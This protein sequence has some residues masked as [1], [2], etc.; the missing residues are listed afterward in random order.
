MTVLLQA[1]FP[2]LRK[3]L[4]SSI[5]LAT[6]LYACA[7][8]AQPAIPPQA[9][10]IDW[11]HFDQL[12][13]AQKLLI[14]TACCGLYI[15]PPLP[16]L[17]G[18]AGLLHVEATTTGTA[19]GVTTLTGNVQAQQ[20]DLRFSTD[21]AVYNENS[22]I[23]TLT[24]NIRIRQPG[25]LLTGNTGAVDVVKSSGDLHEASYVLHE[26]G[27]RGTANIIVYTD[28]AGIITIDNG[29]F[30][31]CE[32][33]DNAWYVK[34][35]N[36]ELNRTTGMGT[37]RSVTLRVKDVPVMYLPWVRFPISDQRV[38][39]F[40]A[41]VI[42]STRDGGL[43]VATPYYLNLA[44]NYDATL[45]P[46]VQTE[47]GVMLGLETRYLG[48]IWQQTTDMHYL[49]DDRL[50]DPA[51]YLLPDTDSPPTPDRWALD[52][53]AGG[54]FGRGWGAYIDYRSVS[55]QDYFQDF[56][57]DGLNST[58]QSYLSRSANL[59]Y[60][61]RDWAFTA[62]T[63][64]V[65]AIDPTISGISEPYRILPRLTLDGYYYLPGGLEYGLT[66]EY[67][68][69]DR[70]L[71]PARFTAAEIA[72]GIL[73][74]GS[75]LAMTP[76]LS[77]PMTNS[78]G[79]FTPTVKYKYASWSLDEQA[80]GNTDSPSRGILSANVDTGLIFERETLISDT[81]FRQTLEP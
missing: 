4:T 8:L 76:Q 45:T 58:T 14:P 30:T 22:Q 3:P 73:V 53:R 25:M 35:K 36:I 72:N 29:V 48:R 43:D 15:E 59:Y 68:N 78:Y 11:V 6:S 54:N 31:R 28:E 19:D 71:N 47:R 27:I 20:E 67:T 40:L 23:A 16:V 38:S 74:T 33:G 18:P 10:D 61:N 39:G 41:P 62:L 7:A 37:A 26:S 17:E 52:Y 50:Y 46:R 42:G 21:K 66:T 79:F 32:P 81:S 63:Q 65:Q 34:G 57:N 51:T 9:A 24:G 13:D 69:F 77:L 60:R 80:A 44:P 64:D 70:D 1:P 2:L 49:P 12:T 56:G 5:V 55:D 75:R